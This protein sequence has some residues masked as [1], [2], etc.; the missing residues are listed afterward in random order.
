MLFDIVLCTAYFFM[1]QSLF[2]NFQ[3]LVIENQQ[4]ISFLIFSR[5]EFVTDCKI[6]HLIYLSIL[7]RSAK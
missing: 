6:D 2:R 4:T 1:N 7:I 3:E 5:K